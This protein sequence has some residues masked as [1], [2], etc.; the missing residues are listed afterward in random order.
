MASST[1]CWFYRNTEYEN[2][3]VMEVSFKIFEEVQG[4]KAVCLIKQYIKLW[5]CSYKCSSD[6]SWQIQAQEQLKQAAG[7]KQNQPP[8]EVMWV[9]TTRDTVGVELALGAGLR[10][11]RF[12]I[13]LAGVGLALIPFFILS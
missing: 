1:H 5:K 3:G 11:T 10:V 7:S 9:T 2:H 4:G 8:N 13:C 12:N 6:H